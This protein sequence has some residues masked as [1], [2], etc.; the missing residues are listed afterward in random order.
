M[1]STVR[2]RVGVVAVNV[3][4][5]DSLERLGIR[6]STRPELRVRVRASK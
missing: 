1:V 5:S 2:V 4:L 3:C 6:R